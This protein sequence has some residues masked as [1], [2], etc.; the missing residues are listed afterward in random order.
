MS[1]KWKLNF[2]I[3]SCI[4]AAA[5]AASTGSAF[6]DQPSPNAEIAALPFVKATAYA[7]A[8]NRYCFPDREY[9]SVE[10]GLL[11]VRQAILQ[12]KS[13]FREFLSK[14]IS[15]AADHLKGDYSACAPAMAYVAKSEANLAEDEIRLDS[16]KKAIEAAEAAHEKAAALAEAERKAS[17]GLAAKIAECTTMVHAAEAFL[18]EG[19]SLKFTSF[20]DSLP[21]C[22]QDIPETPATEKLVADAR[23][24]LATIAAKSK[25]EN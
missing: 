22:V 20:A 2:L 17:E 15:S 5:L 9:G 12:Y 8:I 21:T 14:E 24:A 19:R 25:Q 6:T 11:A 4:L 1:R 16:M 3:R 10:L 23:A 13:D 18:A 7:E